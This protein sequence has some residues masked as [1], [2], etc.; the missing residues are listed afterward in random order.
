MKNEEVVSLDCVWAK[1]GVISYKLCDREFD[2]DHCPFDSVMKQE[3]QNLSPDQSPSFSP[4]RDIVQTEGGSQWSLNPTPENLLQRF[5]EPFSRIQFPDNRL[6]H[7]NHSWIREETGR[8]KVLGVD[9]FWMQLVGPVLSVILP[10]PRSRISYQVPFAWL[11]HREG[12]IP[13]LAPVDGTVIITNENLTTRPELVFN[14]TYEAGWFVRI[15]TSQKCAYA[16]QTR[17]HDEHQRIT[18]KE[19]DIIKRTLLKKIVSNRKISQTQYDGGLLIDYV[20]DALGF[21]SFLHVMNMLLCDN[22]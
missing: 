1:A 2:C 14:D 11:V 13:L 16:R 9:Q 18:Q 20:I 17:L 21:K 15:L 7:A 3:F 8:E 4:D 22:K 12:T 5:L 6:Y 10:Q 19:I